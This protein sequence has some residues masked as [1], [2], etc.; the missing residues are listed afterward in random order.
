MVLQKSLK[1][2]GS[3]SGINITDWKESAVLFDKDQ[4]VEGAVTVL[5]NI[6]FTQ[7]VSG[8]KRLGDIDLEQLSNSVQSNILDT[9]Q[10]MKVVLVTK[11]LLYKVPYCQ[12]IKFYYNPFLPFKDNLTEVCGETEDLVQKA[13]AQDMSIQYFEQ[14]QL[15]DRSENNIHS[16]YHFKV[17]YLSVL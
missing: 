17:M 1:T 9:H 15:I 4:T 14:S 16:V 8:P 6:T 5:G 11:N 7:P 3:I 2:E 12:F 10:N 13:R